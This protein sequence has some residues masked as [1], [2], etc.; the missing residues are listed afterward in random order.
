MIKNIIIFISILISLEVY[1]NK[2][3]IL[4]D[5]IGSG[6]LVEKHFKVIV[7]YRGTLENGLE[8]DSSFK[9]NE[10]FTFQIGLQEVIDGWERGILGMRVGGKRTI[11]IP[12]ELAYGSRG[13]GE[14]IPPNSTLIFE[15]EIIDTFPPSYGIILAKNIFIKYFQRYKSF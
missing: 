2:I 9:R 12:P 11:K 10:P 15:V 8:F 13:A 7:N 5:E 14:L 4:S 1:A 6:T 3:S